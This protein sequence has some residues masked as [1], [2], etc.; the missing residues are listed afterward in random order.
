M[1][2]Q[3]NILGKRVKELR[4]QN[5]MSMDELAKKLGYKS[6]ASIGRIENGETDLPVSKVRDLAN[7]F[8]VRPAYLMGWDDRAKPDYYLNSDTAE[9]AQEIYDDPKLCALF[10]AARDAKPDDL[11]MAADMLKKFKGS[12]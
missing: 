10:D 8:A 7:I 3:D 1:N 11:K 9:L 6:R 2:T 4:E 12:E 5:H